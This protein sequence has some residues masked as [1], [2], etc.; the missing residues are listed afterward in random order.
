MVT[1]AQKRA[2][3]RYDERHTVMVPIKLNKRTDADILVHLSKIVNRQRY[4]KD[5]IREDIIKGGR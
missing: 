1:E 5:L 2:A 4:I 3:K